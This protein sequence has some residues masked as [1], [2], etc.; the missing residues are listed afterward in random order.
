M[1][2]SIREGFGTDLP[3][4]TLFDEPTPAGLLASVRRQSGMAGAPGP[5]ATAGSSR[6]RS[7]PEAPWPSGW[8]A[9]SR[10]RPERLALSYAQSR[11]WFLNQLDPGSADYNIS[12]AA[13]LTGELDERALAAAVRGLFGRHEVLRTVYPET[14][15]CRNK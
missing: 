1:M 10:L 2:G 4:R 13:R 8:P 14:A 12:L 5:V 3:L 15:G 6:T 11:M 9:R 7:A